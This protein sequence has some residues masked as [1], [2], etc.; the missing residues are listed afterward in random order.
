MV[1]AA[2]ASTIVTRLK[3]YGLILAAAYLLLIG[4]AY[5]TQIFAV[6]AFQH[7]FVTVLL[8]GWLLL[9]L[10]RRRGLPTTPLNPLL[11]LNVIVWLVAALASAD[12][13]MAL[14]NVWQPLIGLLLFFV[15]VDLFQGGGERLLL[16]TQ[17]LLAALVVILAGAQLGSWW[18]GWGFGTPRLGWASVL[19]TDLPLPLTPPRLYVPLGV[20]TWLAA[21]VA[22][23][24]VLAFAWGVAARK[25]S[26]RGG[27]LI[28]AALLAAVMLL[29]SSRGGWISLG[30]GAAAFAGLQLLRDERLRRL[31]QRYALPLLIVALAL[32][33]VAVFVLT[34]LSAEVGHFSGDVLRFDL[35]RGALAITRDHPLLG[36]G[37]GEFGHVYRSY[38]DPAYLDNRFSTA[39]NFYFNTLAETGIVGA[40]VALALGGLLLRTWWRG[41]RGAETRA[42]QVRLA[43]A[44][45]ALVGF[46]AQSFFDTFTSLPLVLLA[47]LLAAYCVTPRARSVLPAMSPGRGSRLAAA[48]ALILLLVFGVGL[49]RSDQAQAAFN[50]S[51]RSGSLA[52]AEQADALDPGLHLYTLQVAALT[53]L[54]SDAASAIPL[55]QRALELEPTWDVGWINLAALYQRQGATAQAL[56]ALQQ[57]DAIDHNNGALLNWARL[58]ETTG[59][60]PPDAIEAAYRRFLDGSPG[61]PLSSFWTATELRRQV[62]FAYVDAR[63][64][65]E[66]RYRLVAEHDPA[67]RAALVPAAP[68]SAGEWWIVGEYALTV[69]GDAAQ[70]ER[71]FS[72]ALA[73]NTDELFVGDLYAARA[74]ARLLSDPAGAAR[75]LNLADLVGVSYEE[76]NAIRAQLTTDAAERRRLL[77]AAVPL[78]VIDQNFEGVVFGGRVAGFDLL[79]EMRLPGPGHSLMQPW[80]DLAAD[81]L[82]AGLTD[83]AATVYRAIL[84]RAP[85]EAAAR[86]ALARL[87]GN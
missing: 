21:Y 47:L 11:Y 5:Y 1:F 8:G 78:R 15:M 34:R 3:R 31:A 43:G 73:V 72:T 46:G 61:L 20:S 53:G 42:E 40:L 25:R 81:D 7:V 74:R 85:E 60:A 28:F 86:A 13:R 75:D 77:A 70:A 69:T 54:H 16:D 19:G 32:V 80:Y 82:A 64:L 51:I 45:A 79:P 44:L 56:A 26:T 9:R 39:H 17:F 27:F 48:A 58:A 84:E 62:L 33:G 66:Q 36:V 22:P 37:P 71:A 23:L 87:A 10:V 41:W 63:P 12:P 83:E 2:G 38:R 24:A 57:A 55:Y 59:A 67:G 68:Q 30:A 50:E 18:F 6:R 29:T 4:G 76:P 14:E 65:P 35:W 49:L 52:A